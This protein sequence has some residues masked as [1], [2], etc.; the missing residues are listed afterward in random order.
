MRS[1]GETLTTGAGGIAA[2][3]MLTGALNKTGVGR[4]IHPTTL[5]M[6]KALILSKGGIDLQRLASAHEAKYLRMA[7]EEHWYRIA[8]ETPVLSAIQRSQSASTRGEYWATTAAPNLSMGDTVT[9]TQF[10]MAEAHRIR[11]MMVGSELRALLPL[12]EVQR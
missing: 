3:G 9:E 5:P 2:L 6:S 8:K 4:Y 12:G 11:M 7:A 10:L 1:A